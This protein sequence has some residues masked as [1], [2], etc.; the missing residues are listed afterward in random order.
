MFSCLSF[1]CL[2]PS[3]EKAPNTPETGLFFMTPVTPLQWWRHCAVILGACGTAQSTAGARISILREDEYEGARA[4]SCMQS[5]SWMVQAARFS[6]CSEPGAQEAQEAVIRC[7]QELRERQL[8]GARHTHDVDG[9][10]SFSC[11]P[12]LWL[13]RSPCPVAIARFGKRST[14]ARALQRRRCIAEGA[15]LLV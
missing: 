14:S 4:R 3:L 12:C 2:H 11:S 10:S 13:A 6:S 8:E 5:P 1:F 7:R 9:V 15:L